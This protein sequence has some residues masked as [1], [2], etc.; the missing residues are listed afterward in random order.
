MTT[1]LGGSSVR[2]KIVSLV[3]YSSARSP[4][5]AGSKG[6]D[7]EKGGLPDM[8]FGDAHASGLYANDERGVD[9]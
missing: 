1:G 2:E 6:S 8:F 7:P 5:K 4:S 3:T 9:H